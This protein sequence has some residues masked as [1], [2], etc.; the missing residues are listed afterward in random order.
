MYQVTLE[1]EISIDI[2]NNP[3]PHLTYKHERESF[4]PS[5]SNK[6]FPLLNTRTPADNI[7]NII[8]KNLKNKKK[9][10]CGKNCLQMS[11][12]FRNMSL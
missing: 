6:G 8:G 2:I 3:T 9:I 5:Y 12:Q 10:N 7:M 1:T 4:Q 11:G